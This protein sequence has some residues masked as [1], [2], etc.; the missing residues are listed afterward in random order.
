VSP[1]SWFAERWEITK[2]PFSGEL[3]FLFQRWVTRS[4]FQ[5]KA[6]EIHII[7]DHPNRHGI[8]PKDIERSRRDKKC[9]IIFHG[10][11]INKESICVWTVN[12]QPV[13]CWLRSMKPNSSVPFFMICRE[14]GN[15]K[16]SFFRPW[17]A[18]AR[19]CRCRKMY[20]KCVYNEWVRLCVIFPRLWKENLFW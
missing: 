16:N 4:Q 1:S 5:F 19:N 3:P 17:S 15:Y 11:C 12:Y 2:N 8:S 6:S 13:C 20:A 9:K 18:P 7:F 14:M 10:T